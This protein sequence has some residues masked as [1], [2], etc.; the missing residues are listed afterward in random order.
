MSEEV[1]IFLHRTSNGNLNSS[2]TD[3]IA[4][5]PSPKADYPT[6]PSSV[7]EPPS[8]ML[9]AVSQPCISITG[10]CG[11]LSR[12]TA[13]PCEM[14]K[15]ILQSAEAEGYESFDD[16]VAAYYCDA[17]TGDSRIAVE[18]QLSRNW[19]FP[20][21]LADISQA[22]NNW[23]TWERCGFH[24]E[25]LRIVESIVIA[26]GSQG[27]NDL[28]NRMD[29]LDFGG[30]LIPITEVLRDMKWTIRSKVRR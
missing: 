13:S 23:T 5:R 22:A 21:V 20:R 29:L 16:L 24:E 10:G 26:E 3:L 1:A 17:I 19:R 25:M 30:D 6:N 14:F 18:Q 15:N 4:I 9:P 12:R 8:N 27:R 2:P 28:K 7:A 11:L